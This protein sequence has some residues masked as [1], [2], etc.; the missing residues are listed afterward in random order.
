M[1]DTVSGGQANLRDC[2]EKL[3]KGF[4]ACVNDRVDMS[5]PSSKKRGVINLMVAAFRVYFKI[6]NYRSCKHMITPVERSVRNEPSIV[7]SPYIPKAD[8]VTYRYYKGRLNVF[9]DK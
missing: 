6:G 5:D 7:E 9:E 2:S 1:A 4:G 8:L 3:Q